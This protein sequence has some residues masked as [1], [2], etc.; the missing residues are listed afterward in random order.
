MTVEQ[1]NVAMLKSAY[2]E[3][4]DSKAT[5]VDHWLDLMADEVSVHSL[6]EGAAGVEW[7][8]QCC[9]KPDLRRYFE[10]MA[11]DWEMIHYTIEQY[12]AQGDSVAA[13][14][15]CAWRYRKTG[16]VVKSPKADFVR[17]RNGRIVEF[18]EF[19]DTAKILAATQET[20]SRQ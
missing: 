6:A 19:Y 9:T 2:Q 5:S 18:I 13:R 11:L 1:E 7:T 12:I 4:H 10:G 14:G 8:Q 17:F 20:A 15:T 3:W 16:A